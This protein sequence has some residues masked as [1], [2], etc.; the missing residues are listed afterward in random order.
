MDLLVAWCV[1]LLGSRSFNEKSFT[2]RT[3]APPT[4]LCPGSMAGT[5]CA[6]S[7]LSCPGGVEP[8]EV[9]VY[10]G[11]RGPFA[12]G[13]LC[14]WESAAGGNYSA[15]P[16]CTSRLDSCECPGMQPDSLVTSA[17]APY[18]EHSAALMY[19]GPALLW[20]LT[21]ILPTLYLVFDCTRAGP[22]TQN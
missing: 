9:C 3:K 5:D 13:F 8:Q 11:A 7:T 14:D 16:H 6:A 20:G 2:V 19:A 15:A 10:N 12:H 22:R 1:N 4:C 18:M 17:M 21:L